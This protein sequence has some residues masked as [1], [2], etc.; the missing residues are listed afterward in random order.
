A[1]AGVEN[2]LPTYLFGPE[3]RFRIEPRARVSPAGHA[4]ELYVL[5]AVPL[6]AERF[7]VRICFDEPGYSSDDGVFPSGRF[8]YEAPIDDAIAVH[9]LRFEPKGRLGSR[10][11]QY[12]EQFLSHARRWG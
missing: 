8:R 6:L 7:G 3:A 9:R 5:I 10:F 1:A 11:C 2:P 12:F 4:V